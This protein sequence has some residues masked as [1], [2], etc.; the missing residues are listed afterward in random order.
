MTTTYLHPH[1]AEEAEFHFGP[2]LWDAT[3]DVCCAA[4]QL[5][6]CAHTEAFTEDDVD[7]VEDTEAAATPDPIHTT[8]HAYVPS[9]V[10]RW[11]TCQLCGIG[12]NA[13]IHR[14][15]AD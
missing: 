6:A 11:R 9:G 8:P 3:P 14:Q 2:R 13:S 5:G 4:F 15:P 10:P 7:P 12:A 1:E